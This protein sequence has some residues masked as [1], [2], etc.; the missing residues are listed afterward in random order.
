MNNLNSKLHLKY[1]K[2]VRSKMRALRKNYQHTI[3]FDNF[4]REIKVEQLK[5]SKPHKKST[6][7][8]GNQS[9]IFGQK[10]KILN[11]VYVRVDGAAELEN[12]FNHNTSGFWNKVWSM[13]NFTYMPDW[14]LIA[15]CGGPGTLL[16]QQVLS[17]PPSSKI[18]NLW[19]WCDQ[20]F[21]ETFGLQKNLQQNRHSKLCLEERHVQ[22]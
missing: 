6:I 12:N 18:I 11:S 8:S 17:W 14:L 16:E 22:V 3:L 13:S 21:G 7:F 9:W 10:L 2:R 4:S 20:T 15:Q 5:S 19:F 1:Q